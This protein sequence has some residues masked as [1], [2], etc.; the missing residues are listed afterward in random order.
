[1]PL[2]LNS[3]PSE[4]G[5]RI[6]YLNINNARN[7]IDD[8]VT[9]LHN[10]G[11][12]FHVFCFAES[13][14]SSQV[15]DPEMQVAG[16]NIL[17]LD[18]T[19]PKTTGLLLY[20]A[21]SM[22]CI[23][24]HDLETHGVESIWLKVSIK[25][26][27]PVLIGFLYR[28]PAE[29]IEWQERFHSLMDDVIMMNREV[30][31]FGD[32]NIDLLKPKQKWN[33]TYTMLGLE[34]LTDRPTRITNQTKTLIDHIYVTSKQYIAEV[35]VPDYGTSDHYPIC[36]TWYN[37]RCKFPKIGQFRNPDEAVE[38]WTKTFLSAYDKH[39][40]FRK[41]RVKHVTKPPW[42]TREIDEEI[43]YRDFL[44][45]SGKRELFKRQRN[46]VTS[47]K[48]K[49]KRQ[50]FQKLVVSCKD[51]RQVWKAINLLTRKH[52]SKSQQITNISPNTLNNHFSTIAEKIIL[53]DKSQ[54]NDLGHLK[55]Y[56]DSIDFKSSFMLGPM[57][58]SDVS[59]SLWALK[60][61][62][63]RDL[64][65][66]DRRILKLACP[67]IVETLTYLYNLCIDK[68]C[69]PSKFKQAKVVPI[70]KSGD[71]AD[72]SNYRP[73][74]ILSFLSKPLEKHIYKSLYAYLNNNSLIHENQS[75]FRQNHSCHTALI[76]LVDN[77]LTNINLNEFTGILFVDFAKAFDVIAH[78]LLLRK[79][80]LY[81]LPPMFLRLMS[82][83]LSN[84]KQLV[85]INNSSSTYQPI[86]YGVP[87]GSVL[88]PLLFLL[89]INDL[90]CFVQCLCEMFADDT[91][92]QS[93]DSDTS[94]LTIKLQRGID[95]LVTW[96][97]L[98]HMALNAQKN[99]CMYVSAR[100]KRQ[101]LSPSFQPLFIGQQTIE[102]VHSHKVLG[103]IIDRDL[104]WS[105]HISF[106]GKR[107]AVKIS[108]LAKIKYFLDLHSRSMF[109][110]AHILTLIDYA[111]TLWDSASESNLRFIFR[112]HKRALKLVL[113]KS[114]SLAITDYSQLKT[115]NFKNRLKYNKLVCMHSVVYG[116]APRNI[117]SRF[118]INKYRH[119]HM[120]SFPR[121]RNNLFKASLLYSGGTMWN[122]LPQRLKSIAN[123]HTFK[124]AL[125]KHLLNDIT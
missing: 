81:R 36:L 3:W 120:L 98:N 34:Q 112:L 87:Q 74:S 118:T 9:I 20:F 86:K 117:I 22:D 80:E 103:V 49:A 116:S 4:P 18:P 66:L 83:F 21:S 53:N 113:L 12:H 14:L 75:G 96:S 26:S 114:N 94:K 125:K 25:H 19:G 51:S 7:K 58:T 39:A 48:R 121:P 76:Q 84:R 85:S 69:F 89:Y 50:Y 35:C 2:A 10:S 54:E 107:L 78:S 100:Q 104:S 8:I 29:C 23:R 40:P 110:N 37:K 47:M 97:E 109:F 24:M 33:Q 45:K 102:E 71:T 91:S 31:L 17:R 42:I 41:K 79:L 68:N 64:D 60:Q 52:V 73:I 15:A 70:Y 16:Y 63:T 99:K 38:F 93:H 30:I 62:C 92:L 57:T 5:L 13:R 90:P 122:N 56:I 28:N 55:K 43:Y 119:N 1:M 11:Q 95:R 6:G 106:L 72:P 105:N 59:K 88:G 111:S 115:L 77:L 32:F 61:S 101:K 44:L 123:K 108:Q 46:K 124:T 67:V 65:G 82:S 27:K